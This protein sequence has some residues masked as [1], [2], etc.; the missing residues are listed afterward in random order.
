MVF[1]TICVG[2]IPATLDMI[3]Y[4]RRVQSFSLFAVRSRSKILRVNYMFREHLLSK[5]K[6]ATL[7]FFTYQRLPTQPY[8]LVTS[9][10]FPWI[11]DWMYSF[12]GFFHN[13]A[14]SFLRI[15]LN[16]TILNHTWRLINSCSSIINDISFKL[17][18]CTDLSHRDVKN[19][20]NSLKLRFMFHL[21]SQFQSHLDLWFATLSL[22]CF[23]FSYP[24]SILLDRT[25]WGA[26]FY[27]ASSLLLKRNV[28]DLNLHNKKSFRQYFQFY[29]YWFE[30]TKLTQAY[31]VAPISTRSVFSIHSINFTNFTSFKSRSFNFF[32]PVRNLLATNV[33]LSR[34]TPLRI[35]FLRQI[36]TNTSKQNL[37][38]KYHNVKKTLLAHRS[39][40]LINC[41]ISK[42][43]LYIWNNKFLRFSRTAISL[44]QFLRTKRK[45]N[46]VLKN[47]LWRVKRK[48]NRVYS[49]F[50][51]LIRH[52]R[53]FV[54]R[55]LIYRIRRTRTMYDSLSANIS[56]PKLT[57]KVKLTTQSIQDSAFVSYLLPRRLLMLQLCSVRVMLMNF[58][59]ILTQFNGCT[60]YTSKL[61]KLSTT[62]NKDLIYSKRSFIDQI[63]VC[64]TSGVSVNHLMHY[65]SM[66]LWKYSLVVFSRFVPTS[67]N[68]MSIS[69]LIKQ[70]ST[71]LNYAIRTEAESYHSTS[72]SQHFSYSNLSIVQFE[73]HCRSFSFNKVVNSR[74]LQYRSIR[75]I[76][77][78]SFL[79]YY[80]SLIQ[81]IEITTGRKVL[82]NFGPFL[83]NAITFSDRAKCFAWGSR[84]SGFQRILGPKIFIY[85]ALNILII[86]IRLKDPTFLANW[87]R[88]MLVR[89]SFWK[90]RLIFRYLKFLL[91][92]FI[93]PNFQYFSFKGAKFRLKGKVSVAGNARTRMVF[94]QIG[95]T[96]HST[97]S[98]R[99]SYD[100]S[101]VH[102]FTGIQGFKVWFFY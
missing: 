19:K 33:E 32:L 45:R 37:P 34:I 66:L 36:S 58:I 90:Y 83:E 86:A 82:L 53:R 52:V 44:R 23:N 63:P 77:E 54:R 15:K 64:L 22:P 75:Y 4:K 47:S 68:A 76:K 67:C 96:S 48:N 42:S 11:N 3:I 88:A 49:S 87:I 78:S 16:L 80:T 25:A 60:F 14:F 57:F 71:I 84:I 101:Y 98:Y 13:S 50:F 72:L 85:E 40:G 91:Q 74:T 21:L 61:T 35:H 30:Y 97:T 79:W 59:L 28:H 65:N 31:P 73:A 43:R 94:Y 56:Y 27:F 10:L 102:T 29:N 95:A 99:I 93:K 89:I 9:V 39:K 2:S 62:S 18:S 70:T 6:R 81:F 41:F 7:T 8:V 5:V 24:S 38:C 92:V 17:I 1:K 26:H 69:Q 46:Y 51:T 55:K 12:T 20:V 100:L